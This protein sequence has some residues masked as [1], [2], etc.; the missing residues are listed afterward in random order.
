MHGGTAGT[1]REHRD[2][3]A[4]VRL[5]T[6]RNQRF[7]LVVRRFGVDFREIGAAACRRWRRRVK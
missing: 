2:V 3:L 4:A 1:A 7:L 5:A 6:Q